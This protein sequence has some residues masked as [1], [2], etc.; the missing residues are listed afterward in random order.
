MLTNAQGVEYTLFLL[1]ACFLLL[2]CFAES[3]ALAKDV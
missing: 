1:F 3:L 2:F